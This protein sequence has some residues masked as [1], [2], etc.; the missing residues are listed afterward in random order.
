MRIIQAHCY[1][2]NRAIRSGQMHDYREI[3]QLSDKRLVHSQ[4]NHGL[5]YN[6][7]DLILWQ[8]H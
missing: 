2:V 4:K 7:A 1:W 8:V 3:L 5:A 6:F